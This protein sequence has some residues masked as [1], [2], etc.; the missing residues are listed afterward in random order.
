LCKEAA[1]VHKVSRLM[2]VVSHEWGHTLLGCVEES[3]ITLSQ[4]M[5]YQ[6]DL[7]WIEKGLI[8]LL[9]RRMFDDAVQDDVERIQNKMD[10]CLQQAGLYGSDINLV[11]MTGGGTAIPIIQDRVKI[12]YPHARLSRANMMASVGMGLGY[13]AGRQYRHLN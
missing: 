7:S 2:D 9:T 6:A 10:D 8:C 11:I 5:D 13:E 4:M 12:S 3:K 1:D